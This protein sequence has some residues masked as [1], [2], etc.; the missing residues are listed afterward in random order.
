LPTQ[1]AICKQVVVLPELKHTSL[2]KI[3]LCKG[4]SLKIGRK[5]VAT[6]FAWNTGE[7]SDSILINHEGIYWVDMS[8]FGCTN[9]DSFEVIFYAQPSLKL[10]ADTTI[11]EGSFIVLVSEATG[12]NTY[13]WFPATDLSDA[14]VSSPTAKPKQDVTYVVTATNSFNCSSKDTIKIIVQKL[15]LIQLGSDT[16][17]CKGDSLQLNA[18]NANSTF[19][20]QDGYN[21]QMRIVKDSG[22]YN[23][24]VANNACSASDTIHI[25]FHPQPIFQLPSDTAVCQGQQ[26]SI[27]TRTAETYSYQWSPENGLS[28]VRSPNP[29]VTVSDTINYIVS[30]TNSFQC[31]AKDSIKVFSLNTPWINLG[32]DTTICPGDTLI[33]DAKHNSAMYNWSNG[34][35]TKTNNVGAEGV[36]SVF[37]T[38]DGCSARDTIKVDMRKP[39]VFTINRTV[40]SVCKNDT[41]VLQ[42]AGGD[43][44]KWYNND[45]TMNYFN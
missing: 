32:A 33:L 9:R 24:K 42:A 26:F 18:S 36:Y 45:S 14:S 44:Y 28:D 17:F 39:P 1:A 15:P 30:V 23:V 7:V 8:R 10:A 31:Y 38:K 12:S 19:Q 27:A 13:S 37:I 43:R 40:A 35:S 21:Q 3:F 11:C 25:A 4:D 2:T 16:A 22:F 6:K 34:V 29:V 41:L 5:E 20:W